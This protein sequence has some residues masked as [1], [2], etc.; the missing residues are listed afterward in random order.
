MCQIACQNVYQNM[1]TGVNPDLEQ[2]TLDWQMR[3]NN[4]NHSVARTSAGASKHAVG[5]STEANARRRS[6]SLP[7]ERRKSTSSNNN[8]SSRYREA[9]R[10]AKERSIRSQITPGKMN[11]KGMR[12][13]VW[14]GT[15]R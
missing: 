6:K 14:S 11:L 13:L 12:E 9:Y 3:P 8:S 7:R 2:N 1:R 10:A 5:Y 15:R 4:D